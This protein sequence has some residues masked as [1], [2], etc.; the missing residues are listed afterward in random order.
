MKQFEQELRQEAALEAARKIM[1]AARTA[2]KGKGRDTIEILLVTGDDLEILAAKMDELA[3]SEG[4]HIFERDAKNVRQ[5]QA[6]IVLGSKISAMGLSYCGYCG[7][8]CT[9][10]PENAPCVFNGIDLGIALGSAA[11]KAAD[12]RVDSR[13]LYSAGK[14]ALDLGWMPESAIACAIPVSISSKSP[15]FDRK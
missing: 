4:V 3:I 14:A 13:I 1:T 11:A 6:L 10:K 5:S 8:S 2:P 15:Y 9:T 7:Y 12:C